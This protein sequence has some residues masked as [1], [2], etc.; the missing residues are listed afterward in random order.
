MWTV[1]LRRHGTQ[2][3]R[4]VVHKDGRRGLLPIQELSTHWV[5]CFVALTKSLNESCEMS[6]RHFSLA[7]T[8]TRSQ[9]VVFARNGAERNDVAIH[10]RRGR[11]NVDCHAV[12]RLPAQAGKDEKEDGFRLREEGSPQASDVAIHGVT[13]LQKYLTTQDYLFQSEKSSSFVNLLSI[14]FHAISLLPWFRMLRRRP[15]YVLDI[16]A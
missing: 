14:A 5:F 12:A 2:A 15:V 11:N 8:V 13:A 1:Y 7:K 10:D 4:A 16:F 3:G 6:P 9:I